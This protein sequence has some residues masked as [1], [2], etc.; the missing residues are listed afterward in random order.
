MFGAVY[1]TNRDNSD[2]REKAG[3]EGFIK[4][5]AY[6][7]F[8]EFLIEIFLDLAKTY[9][10]TDP[11]ITKPD[12]RGKT[13]G[14]AKD[15]L[16]RR[17]EQER[18]AFTRNL[19]TWRRRLPLARIRMK[20]L[21]D[22]TDA[23]LKNAE[24]QQG[25]RPQRIQAAYDLI[26]RCRQEFAGF[27]A[28]MGTEPPRLSALSRSE[29]QVFDS[30]L[31]DR[32]AFEEESI[33]KLSQFSARCGQIAKDILPEKDRMKWVEQRV[34]EAKQ[35]ARQALDDEATE[36]GL[37]CT[38]LVDEEVKDWRAKHELALARIVD[39]AVEEAAGG[40]KGALDSPERLKAVVEGM[41]RMEIELR[42]VYLPFWQAVK[43]QIEA[44]QESEGSEEMLGNLYRRT[45]MLEEQSR[46]LGEL[47]QLG[48]VIE[49]L[50][51]EYRSLFYNVDQS[52]RAIAGYVKPEG[53]PVLEGLVAGI[54][55]L[56][57]KQNLLTPLH[58]RRT[59]ATFDVSGTDI[60][61]F[62][63]R[64]YPESRRQGTK[65]EFTSEFLK[66]V[67]Q[68]ANQA[69]ILASVANL[70]ANS[71]YWVSRSSRARVVRLGTF[72][73]GFYVSD[74]GPGVAPR[75]RPRVFDPFFGRRPNGRG[76]GLYIAKTN[77]EAAGY[78][79]RLLDDPPSGTLAGAT[80][81]ITPSE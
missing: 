28:E 46:V 72:A 60:R 41:A 34:K 38:R 75:D 77:L 30:Y 59:S 44:L 64:L 55:S 74:S 21:F 39:D 4:N 78:H 14:S 2:L 16:K 56:E 54:K 67:L 12:R 13:R 35:K 73:E 27:I 63:E 48:L 65:I 23:Q 25:Y 20:E 11:L 7:G 17:A 8:R 37:L 52:L 40:E 51:H 66:L 31:T 24:T 58:Q 79:L 80:F 3:R 43:G 29:Q 36:V 1:L 26:D 22:D 50:D 19:E 32:Q 62:V 10:S 18:D 15:R 69:T 42:E 53:K 70:V 61:G 45:E 76:L 57:T 49:S 9:Y 33:K 81:L 47:A 71:L 5:G 6:R 68:K